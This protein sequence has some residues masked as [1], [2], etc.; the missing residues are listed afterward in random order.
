MQIAVHLR[1]NCCWKDIKFGKRDYLLLFTDEKSQIFFPSNSQFKIWASDW[2]DRLAKQ[3]NV[4]MR[5]Y[6][7]SYKIFVAYLILFSLLST[8]LPNISN[9]M[10]CKYF[11]FFYWLALFIARRYDKMSNGKGNINSIVLP[12]AAPRKSSVSV[13]LAL[14]WFVQR[15][16]IDLFLQSS[17]MYVCRSMDC[18]GVRFIKSP[19]G[20]E[21]DK[22]DLWKLLFRFRLQTWLDINALIRSSLCVY[23]RVEREMVC[24]NGVGIMSRII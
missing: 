2:T 3:L 8:W 18:R 11:N 7:F 17:L 21:G 13:C 19:N 1:D 22:S 12:S 4:L 20:E 9:L 10:A 23:A 6:S 14:V 5:Q 15:Q 24:R 16:C